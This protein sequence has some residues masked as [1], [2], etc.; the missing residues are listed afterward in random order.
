MPSPFPGMDP[1][2]EGEMWQEFPATLASEI[3]AQLLPKLRPKYVA[4]LEKR[5]V[6]DRPNL[7]ILEPPAARVVYPDVHVA[8][9]RREPQ[10]TAQT[11]NG[12]AI[13]DPS[14]LLTSRVIDEVPVTS[15]HIRDVA[16]RRLV[17]L[18]EILSP[19]NKRGTGVDEYFQ[20]RTELMRTG[21]HIL[22]IDLLV[23]GQRIQLEGEPPP[24]PYYVYL[25]RAD[26]RPI[27]EVWAI[28]LQN[29]LPIVPVPLLAPDPDVPLDLQAAVDACFQLVGYEELLDYRA[30]PPPGLSV[31]DTTWAVSVLQGAGLRPQ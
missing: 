8:T 25:S 27:T 23:Q 10:T 30:P 31:E 13:T 7:G 5:Y 1:Y 11:Q 24:A 6:F 26:R 19:V 20:R 21:T 2:L 4:L 29:R 22:E 9:R 15:I 14:I 16:E 28:S 17:T 18:I 3:R 12:L